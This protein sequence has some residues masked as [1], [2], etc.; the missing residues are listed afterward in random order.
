MA[1]TH[2][3]ISAKLFSKKLL[4]GLEDRVM[5][6]QEY[7]SNKSLSEG[8]SLIKSPEEWM[9]EYRKFSNKNEDNDLN[10]LIKAYLRG[11]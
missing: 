5:M 9:E 7:A 10:D 1:T 8:E 4:R 3:K 6:F 11:V 2:I